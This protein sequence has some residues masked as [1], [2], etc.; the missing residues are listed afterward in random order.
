MIGNIVVFVSVKHAIPSK[1]TRS[2][3]SLNELVVIGME[4]LKLGWRA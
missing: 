3:V 1:M 2:T 4:H